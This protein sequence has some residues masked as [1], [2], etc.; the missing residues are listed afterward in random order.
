MLNNIKTTIQINTLFIIATESLCCK[1][2]QEIELI[3]TFWVFNFGVNTYSD[4]ES[5]HWL[6]GYGIRKLRREEK[7]KFNLIYA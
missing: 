4:L 2:V 7:A 3:R 1:A 6:V 5:L